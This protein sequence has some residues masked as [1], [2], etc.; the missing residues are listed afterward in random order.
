[1]NFPATATGQAYAA[2]LLTIVS[3]VS[4]RQV[5]DPA[6]THASAH[7]CRVDCQLTQR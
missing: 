4:Y 1:M 7:A 5:A 3:V 2:W 6:A